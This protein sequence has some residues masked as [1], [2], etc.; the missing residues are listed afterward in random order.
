MKIDFQA[1]PRLRDSLSYLYVEHAILEREASA[2]LVLQETGRTTVPVADL[3]VLLVGPGVTLTHAAVRL[4]AESGCSVVWAGQDACGFYACGVGE[5]HSARHII[6]Q[7]RLV[8]YPQARIK[9]VMRMYAQRFGYDLDP[10]WRIEQIRGMEGARVR[11]AYA[12]A[13][14]KFGVPWQGRSLRRDDWDANDPVNQALSAANAVL[15]GVCHAAIVSG[16]YSP[17]LGF[18]HTGWHLAFVYDIADLYKVNLTVP[19]A[20]GTVAES[21]SKVVSRAR[22]ACREAIREQ[23]LLER[24]LP[25][26][27]RLLDTPE[28]VE[29]LAQEQGKQVYEWWDCSESEL[30]P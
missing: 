6:Q 27:A 1:L 16:G 25:D 7:A 24:I 4:L 29:N 17:A 19:V 26:I 21:G 9:V 13:S 11:Q 14:R 23:K 28:E 20:F 5:T 10:G 2:I 12:D 22:E 8:S 30:E 3:C 15:H 18:L